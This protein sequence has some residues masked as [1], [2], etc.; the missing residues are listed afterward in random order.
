[1]V[2]GQVGDSTSGVVFLGIIAIGDT[3]RA[4]AVATIQ[5]LHS[6]GIKK[7]VII[8]GDNQRTVNAIAKQAVSMKRSVISFQRTRLNAF[9]SLVAEYKHVGMVG[10]GVNDA[11]YGHCQHRNCYGRRWYRCCH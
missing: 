7:V 5:A 4:D 1:M 8:S 9:R 6:V 10:D 11:C 2:V 3:I